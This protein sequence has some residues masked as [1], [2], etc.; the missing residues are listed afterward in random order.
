MWWNFVGR[1]HEEIVGYREEWQRQISP[2]GAV[3]DDSQD[4]L[5]GRFGIVAGDHHPPIPAP[6]LPNARLR[7]RR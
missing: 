4:V 5:D 1:S 7:E 3:V 2:G 6:A